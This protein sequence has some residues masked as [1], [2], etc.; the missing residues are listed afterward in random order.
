VKDAYFTASFFNGMLKKGPAEV[1]LNHRNF[2][3]YAFLHTEIY[4]VVFPL[5]KNPN[6]TAMFTALTLPVKTDTVQYKSNDTNDY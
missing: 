4:H 1:P 3:I 2:S 6:F 5:R